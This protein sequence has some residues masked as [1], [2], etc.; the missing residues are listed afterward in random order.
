MFS[1]SGQL[2]KDRRFAFAIKIFNYQTRGAVC[3]SFENGSRAVYCGRLA[4]GS[5]K[6]CFEFKETTSFGDFPSTTF[7]HISGIMTTWQET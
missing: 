5:D 1:F 7:S 3:T 4:D 2:N 6:S